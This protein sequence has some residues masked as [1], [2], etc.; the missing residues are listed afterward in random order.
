MDRAPSAPAP[1]V[2]PAY[3]AGTPLAE[4]I[5]RENAES[6][7]R[8]AR[9]AERRSALYGSSQPNRGRGASSAPESEGKG[10]GKPKGENKNGPRRRRKPGEAPLLGPWLR[11]YGVMCPRCHAHRSELCHTSSGEFRSVWEP[12]RGR[13][14]RGLRD[15]RITDRKVRPLFEQALTAWEAGMSARE[16][17]VPNSLPGVD[18]EKGTGN[19]QHQAQGTR[20]VQVTRVKPKGRVQSKSTS[21]SGAVGVLGAWLGS[22]VSAFKSAYS[23]LGEAYEQEKRR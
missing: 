14:K 8:M 18:R 3:R 23:E 2:P 13:E 20:Q 16:A 12:H 22:W 5:E 9:E 17:G 19:G 7:K 1:Y 4:K 11:V 21:T 15:V 6:R 10:K